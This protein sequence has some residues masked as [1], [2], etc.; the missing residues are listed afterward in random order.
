MMQFQ[1]QQ[2]SWSALVREVLGYTVASAVALVVDLALLVFLTEA[3]VHY[4][5]AATIA[6]LVGMLVVYLASV[7]WIFSWRSHKERK[8]IEIGVFLLTGLIGLLLNLGILW[9]LTSVFGIFYLL[10]KFVSV[11]FVFTWHFV[12][13][14]LLL[15]T[16]L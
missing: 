13:R 3:G 8:H 14:K 6:F 7:R 15:F 9:I 10:S 2:A 5:L 12:T 4:L 16:S 1:T 11:G